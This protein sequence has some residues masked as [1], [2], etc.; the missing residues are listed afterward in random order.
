[1]GK[2]KKGELRELKVQRWSRHN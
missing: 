1:V 2:L